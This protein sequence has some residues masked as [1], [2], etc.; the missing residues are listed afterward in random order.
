MSPHS[1][2]TIRT[3]TGGWSPTWPMD[4][5][6]RVVL[7]VTGLAGLFMTA[8]AVAA[9]VAPSWFADTAG[10]PRHPHFVHDAGGFQLGIGAT[11]LLAVPGATGPRWPWPAC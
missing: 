7:A 1:H 4:R 2:R 3:P 9:L 11:L 10:F 5:G 8:A 6:R